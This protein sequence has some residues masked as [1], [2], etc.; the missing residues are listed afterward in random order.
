MESLHA[1]YEVGKLSIS[2]RRGVITLIPKVDSDLL[3]LQNCR[4]ITLLNT[5]HKIASKARRIDTIL[6]KLV[7]LAR[8]NRLHE[9]AIYR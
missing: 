2:K 4:P 8:S 5:D 1:A 9:G 3:D 7:H 6:P